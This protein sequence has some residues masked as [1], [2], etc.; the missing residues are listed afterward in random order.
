MDNM[1]L[2]AHLLAVEYVKHQ[3]EI[4]KILDSPVA[5]ANTYKL[6]YKQILT[7]LKKGF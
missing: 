3:V 6:A 5:Y 2:R 1:E 7:E 4:G